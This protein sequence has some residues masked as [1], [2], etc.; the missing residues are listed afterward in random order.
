[1][2][3]RFDHDIWYVHHCSLSLDIKI[4]YLTMLKVLRA[5]GISA[6]GTATMEKFKGN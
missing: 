3:E 5:E 4:L 6:P 2:K 1:L